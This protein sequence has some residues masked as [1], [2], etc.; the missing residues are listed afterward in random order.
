MIG[1]DDVAKECTYSTSVK[2]ISNSGIV[3]AIKL[4]D[5]N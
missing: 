1:D 4:S 2:C 5:F 3:Y